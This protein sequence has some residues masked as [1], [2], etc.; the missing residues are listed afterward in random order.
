MSFKKMS[1]RTFNQSHELLNLLFYDKK[2]GLILLVKLFLKRINPYF[3]RL[4]G[5]S[6]GTF[7]KNFNRLKI[8]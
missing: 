8:C 6:L 7:L 4:F 2:E 1:L 3:C 5:G